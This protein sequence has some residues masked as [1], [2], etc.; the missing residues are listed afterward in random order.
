MQTNPR[1][2]GDKHVF[3]VHQALT[4]S[5]NK[6]PIEDFTKTV[7]KT[8]D[9]ITKLY[10]NIT[11]VTSKFEQENT[12]VA[13]DLTLY[14]DDGTTKMVNLFLI[15]KNGK[16]QAKN[17]GAKSFFSK[18]FLS[19][20]VQEKFNEQLEK[21]YLEYLKAIAKETGENYI[22]SDTK[23]LKKIISTHFPKFT[24]EIE[25]HRNKL[26]YS[27]REE[28]F[29]LLKDS[30]NNKD[31]GYYHA[32][33]TL[34]MTD[35]TTV[36][37]RYGKYDS[38]VKVERFSPSSPY[39]NLIEIYKTGKNTVGIKYGE[40]ALTL[41]FK[42]ESG[43]ISSIK[44]ATS[45]DKFPSENENE[46]NNIKTKHKMF[47]LLD[48]HKYQKGSNQSNAIGKC[49]EA[50]TYY[51][52]LE[53]YPNIK[54]VDQD[55][56]VEL[57][58]KY[59]NIVKPDVLKDIFNSTSTIVP[60]IR[61]KLYEKYQDYEIESI[62]LVPDSYIED[63]LSTGDIKLI[64]RINEKYKVETISLKALAK[65]SSKL[66]TKNPGVGSILG[67]TYFNVGDLTPTVRDVKERFLRGDL[68]HTESLQELAIELGRQ[69]EQT[70]QNN[71]KRGIENLLGKSIVAITFY[72]EGS[73]ICK[74]HNKIKSV[75]KV[76]VKTPSSTQNTL[77]WNNG[78]ELIS[79]RM[80]FSRSQKYGWSSVK[81]VSE[82]QLTE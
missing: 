45:Y 55:D 64:L 75:V 50:I 43:P 24:T 6:L 39:F 74:E 51:Y 5:L 54:Q 57:I 66:T 79:L 29:T 59:S 16:I 13:K 70:S 33:H 20:S 58:S 80:K 37:T 71:L 9:F 56:C 3:L 30:Y 31:R 38:D 23:E 28:C 81:L 40:T 67:P 34:F 49:H 53:Y 68:D 1:K 27:L 61:E 14:L 44:L 10:P 63:K 48:N 21:Y 73:S 12:N 26:L 8:V 25:Q 82:Y 69:L 18:Y 17:I 47:L 72:R 42:F 76:L 32:Y 4:R 60:V 35:E 41:R 62:E 46:M 11:S 19:D 78:L 65:R 22:S 15:K 77:I 36:I 52:F 7:K 2:I